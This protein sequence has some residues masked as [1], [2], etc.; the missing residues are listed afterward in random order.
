MARWLA[1]ALALLVQGCAFAPSA[2]APL[3]WRDAAFGAVAPAVDAAE[4]FRIDD[5]LR[6]RLATLRTET[7]VSRQR[8]DRMVALVFGADRRGFTY[9]AG[10]STAAAETWLRRSGDC[11]SLAVLTYAAARELGLQPQLQE[12]Q[13]PTRYERRG[14]LDFV[15]RH[16][17]VRIRVTSH[18][19]A[20]PVLRTTSVTVD[21]EPE[22]ADALPGRPLTEREVLARFYNNLG[23]Q[24]MARGEQGAAYGHLKAAV[25][26]DPF[27]PASYSN[28][29]VIYRAAG[30][31]ADAEAWL[32][33]AAALSDQP[34][35]PLRALH[36]L[37]LEQ[38]RTADAA[39][40]AA[41][42]Q[43]RR[44]S[45]PYHWIALGQ[46]HLA[47]GEGRRAV[48]A[49]ERA[50]VLAS[51][52]AEVHRSLAIAY[53]QAGRPEDARRQLALLTGL[54]SGDPVTAKL[55]RKLGEAQ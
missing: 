18:T 27:F 45:D 14:P 34:E 3:P 23:V 2:D 53:W 5:D 31:P 16:I 24:F 32:L 46:Q 37:L 13:V 44:E 33:R 29:A 21:F 47:A 48:A 10:D 51:G 4:L 20:D 40:Y 19:P 12:V 39:R 1:L 28:L 50:Q 35:L 6:A 11:I 26:A 9:A 42:L 17:N 55:R 43:A 25:R 54:H 8:V 38:G 36:Q 49:L 22:S 7:G 30:W 41:L 15:N 52:F